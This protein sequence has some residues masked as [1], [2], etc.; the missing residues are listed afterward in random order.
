MTDSIIQAEVARCQYEYQ[1]TSRNEGKPTFSLTSGRLG[2]GIARMK[3]HVKWP[4]EFCS[5]QA[6]S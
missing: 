1:D 6:G 2:A 3:N 5:V 4:Q